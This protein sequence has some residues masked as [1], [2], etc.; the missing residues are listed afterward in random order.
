VTTC[1]LNAAVENGGTHCGV[2]AGVTPFYERVSVFFRK[3]V[4]KKNHISGY[5]LEIK[6]V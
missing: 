5:L 1:Y 6:L 3:A 2:T 4:K